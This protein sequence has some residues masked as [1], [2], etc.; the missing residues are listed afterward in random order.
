MFFKSPD[1]QAGLTEIVGPAGR[2]CLGVAPPVLTVLLLLGGVGCGRVKQQ[3]KENMDNNPQMRQGAV[4]SAR[5]SCVQTAMAKLPKVPGVETRVQSYCD[6]FATKGLNKFS[7]SELAS[8]S[9][10]GGH[11]TP[12]QQQKLND[13]V[14]LCSSSLLQHNSGGRAQ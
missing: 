7:N 1:K 11:F 12:E 3:I 4:E 6:C 9:L 10:H 8:I 5:K 14:Q 13:A 2:A